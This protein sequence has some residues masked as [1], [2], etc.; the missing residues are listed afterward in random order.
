[1]S[2]YVS[3][4]VNLFQT[5]EVWRGASASLREVFFFLSGK[6]KEIITR[7]LKGGLKLIQ[8]E[9]ELF[10][11]HLMTTYLPWYIIF[12]LSGMLMALPSNI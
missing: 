8:N 4:H 3:V 11:V 12:L 9:N 10:S 2:K 5:F 6:S 7:E 1:M